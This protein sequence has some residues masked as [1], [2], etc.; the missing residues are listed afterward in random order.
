[1]LQDVVSADI[2]KEDDVTITMK[3]NPVVFGDAHLANARCSYHLHHSQR[4]VARVVLV[5]IKLL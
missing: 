4:G 2:S 5:E 1:M 3:C